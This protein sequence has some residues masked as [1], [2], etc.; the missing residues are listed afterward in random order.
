MSSSESSV[1]NRRSGLSCTDRAGKSYSSKRSSRRQ[2]RNRPAA[3]II[4]AA[5]LGERFVSTFT[6]HN[7]LA[8]LVR[9]QFRF[10]AK[11][12]AA[13]LSAGA[14]FAGTGANQVAFELRQAAKHSQHKA[15]VRRRG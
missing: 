14:A 2:P 4:A 10:A 9:R 7:C 5:D 13:R 3:H 12:D 8:L 15:T 6:A 1:Q 11:L